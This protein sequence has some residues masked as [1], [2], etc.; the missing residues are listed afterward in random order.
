MWVHGVEIEGPSAQDGVA[1]EEQGAVT[2]VIRLL[3]P[4]CLGN[5]QRSFLIMGGSSVRSA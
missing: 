2:Q 3:N 1:T 5:H 4:D